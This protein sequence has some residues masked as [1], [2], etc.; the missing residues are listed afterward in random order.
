MSFSS[1]SHGFPLQPYNSVEKSNVG[2]RHVKPQPVGL[3]LSTQTSSSSRFH[4]YTEFRLLRV[5]SKNNVPIIPSSDIELYTSNWLGDSSTRSGFSMQVYKGVLKPTGQAVALKRFKTYLYDKDDDEAFNKYDQAINDFS[6]ELQILSKSSLQKHRNIVTL[7]GITFDDDN[8][9]SHEPHFS[10]PISIVELAHSQYP[11][12]SLYFNRNNNHNLPDKISFE[13]SASFIADVA[14]GIAALHKHDLIHADLKPENILLFPDESSLNG[15]VAKISDFGFSGMT[16]YT[17]K[18]VRG[19]LP[20]N[21]PRGGTWEWNAPECLIKD[22]RVN[23][24]TRFD[25]HPVNQPGRDIYSFG[26]VACFIALNGCYPRSFAENLDEAKLTDT[27]T[28]ITKSLLSTYYESDPDT[29]FMEK[30]L[31]IIE[32]TLNPQP[33][34]RMKTLDDMRGFLFDG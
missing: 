7:L 25:E 22:S 18:G 8:G 14:D 30:L 33:E 13:T 2:R 3:S 21:V 6:F 24:R 5:I 1:E 15:L 9:I 4:D 26:L 34:K 31:Y 10:V 23:D 16:T 17:W 27:M 20:D 19:P 32:N 29:S 12:L 28:N 11:D